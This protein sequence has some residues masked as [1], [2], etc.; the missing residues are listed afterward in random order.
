MITMEGGKEKE[1]TG[2]VFWLYKRNSSTRFS[3]ANAKIMGWIVLVGL[4]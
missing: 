2:D 1:K 4:G 3:K